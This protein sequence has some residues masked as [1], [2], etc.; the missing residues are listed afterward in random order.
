MEKD[1]MLAAVFPTPTMQGV[2]VS[3]RQ[4]QRD[5]EEELSHLE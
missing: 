1:G 4:L 3:P 2:I 5:I